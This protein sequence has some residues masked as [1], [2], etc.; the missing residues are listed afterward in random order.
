VLAALAP[1]HKGVGLAALGRHP[2]PTGRAA[3]PVG[4]GADRCAISADVPHLDKVGTVLAALA[5]MHKGVGLAALG[6]HPVPTGRAAPPVGI[7]AD[8]CAISADVP[9]LDKVV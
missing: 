3:P 2:V 6:R 8:R 4:I 5:P 1:T 7:G 9:H